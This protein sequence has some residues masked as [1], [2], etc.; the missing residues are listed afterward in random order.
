V[1]KLLSLIGSKGVSVSNEFAAI[2]KFYT[3][4]CVVF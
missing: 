4:T 1:I 2:T 3:K